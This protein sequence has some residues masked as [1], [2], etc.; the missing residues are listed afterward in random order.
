[1]RHRTVSKYARNYVRARAVAHMDCQVVLSRHRDGYLD[2]SSGLYT[3]DTGTV[4]YKG[5]ARIW[6]SNTGTIINVGEADL[7]TTATYCSIP[8]DSE[9]PR[10]DDLLRVV[11][12]SIDTALETR[13]F[14]VVGVDGGGLT[15]ATRRMQITA[16]AENRS[17]RPEDVWEG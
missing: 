12:A 5:I 16:L 9:V 1:M 2:Q 15:R 4:I 10:V 11:S 17:W 14:R 3:A 13:G 6:D 8:F 7:A